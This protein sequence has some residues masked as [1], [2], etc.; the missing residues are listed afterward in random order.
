MTILRS[1]LS[2]AVIVSF[3]TANNLNAAERGFVS[4]RPGATDNPK[5]ANRGDS[6]IET[7]LYGVSRSH[8]DGVHSTT[9]KVGSIYAIH[10]ITQNIEVQAGADVLV[11]QTHTPSDSPGQN[12]F[13]DSTLRAKFNWFGNDEGPIAIAVIPRVT[14]GGRLEQNSLSGGIGVPIG[15]SLPD[16]WSLTIMPQLDVERL[17]D[18]KATLE[19]YTGTVLGRDLGAGWNAF[20][21]TASRSGDQSPLELTAG[22]GATYEIG[23]KVQLDASGD[24]GISST[25]V[26]RSFSAGMVVHF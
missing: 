11:R 6:R 22:F 13:G 23:P 24:F 7:G 21:Q 9:T 4:D 17:S 10:G 8:A 16:D 15:L 3:V 5:T 12:A 19:L 20:A 18:G 25:A 2:K 14:Y 1:V 26:D